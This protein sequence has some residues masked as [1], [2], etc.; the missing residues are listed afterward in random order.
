MSERP[1]PESAPAA[2]TAP[3]LDHAVKIEQLLLNG[4]DAYFAGQYDLAISV[5]TR[6]LFLDRSHARARAYIER[7]RRAL[8]ERQ[9]ESEE[10]L[11]EGVQAFRAGD[12]VGARRLLEQAL[13]LGAPAE[14]ARPVLDRLRASQSDRP[15]R[16]QVP[17]RTDSGGGVDV[18]AMRPTPALGWILR[19]AVGGAVALFVVIAVV[20]VRTNW[21]RGADPTSRDALARG[22]GMRE[23]S[24]APEVPHLGAL[25]LTRARAQAAEGRLR[26]ALATLGQVRPTDPAI[27][28]VDQ[29]RS[30]LQRQLLALTRP[31][32]SGA[33]NLPL[34]APIR[35]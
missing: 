28:E 3:Q 8:A 30:V 26:D 31:Q 13:N 5:W 10:L 27:V 23:E 24:R 14:E 4:L 2:R 7:A 15:G 33:G 21:E 29:Y 1:S 16:R 11:H 19:A 18:A 6:V 12:T 9:R 35:P 17:Q 22:A 32:Q 20:M 34:P 25:A